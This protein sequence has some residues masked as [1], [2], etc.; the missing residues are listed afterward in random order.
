MS[1]FFRLPTTGAKG[2]PSVIEKLLGGGGSEPTG[3]AGPRRPNVNLAND[4]RP[5]PGSDMP[6]GGGRLGD[7]T[8]YGPSGRPSGR[9][10]GMFSGD[11]QL[12][13]GDTGGGYGGFGAFGGGGGS[14]DP[15][16]RAL[17]RLNA[18]EESPIGM[19]LPHAA[20][21]YYGANIPFRMQDM[22]PGGAWGG[23]GNDMW[24]GGT[25]DNL[26]QGFFGG[27][28]PWGGQDGGSM[29]DDFWGG[30]TAG[31]EVP[32]ETPAPT[33]TPQTPVPN[34][35]VDPD[36]YIVRVNDGAVMYSDGNL[37]FPNGES[38][39]VVPEWADGRWDAPKPMAERN[40]TYSPE[41]GYVDHRRDELPG[42]QTGGF[43]TPQKAGG[44]DLAMGGDDWDLDKFFADINDTL[45]GNNPL[46]APL[47]TGGAYGPYGR[48][49]RPPATTME[50]ISG[51]N[52]GEGPDDIGDGGPDGK[53]FDS[54][55]SFIDAA[56]TQLG[57]IADQFGK[58]F[59]SFTTSMKND[60][61]PIAPIASVLGGYMFGGIPG[62]VK[63]A[64]NAFSSDPPTGNPFGG[65][66]DPG[67]T[68]SFGTTA[69]QDAA[70][71]SA[72]EDSFDYGGGDN[73]GDSG[74]GEATSGEHGG[75]G[76]D[77]G[78]PDSD[79]SDEFRHG[80]YTGKGKDKRLQP[81]AV[82]GKVHEGEFVLNADAVKAL[83]LPMLERLNRMRP[84]VMRI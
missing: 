59:D 2:R 66:E 22:S 38:I 30:S 1:T 33:E 14:M 41:T 29:W 57:N 40:F 58:D 18:S 52:P 84:A 61:G 50:E 53:G 35:A 55:S 48:P 31:S 69:A 3:T 51:P 81:G 83:G 32:V 49:Y 63:G 7:F 19:A 6:T 17:D 79:P 28:N 26:A 65:G 46:G 8:G 36:R 68:G 74:G 72:M 39:L 64:I 67:A 27:G 43:V 82:A 13:G 62:A 23:G 15:L 60:L 9:E 12:A 4:Y 16:T 71:I 77:M 73:G 56:G 70:N 34:D 25:F 75:G 21:S 78:G 76:A 11:Y 80:G 44:F 24:G 54:F 10:P 37:V 5:L 42:Y 47:G 20:E 45:S